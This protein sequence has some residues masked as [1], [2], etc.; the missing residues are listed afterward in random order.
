MH[1]WEDVKQQYS[2]QICILWNRI[3]GDRFPLRK[4]L[5]Q[6]N[7]I[8]D[9]HVDADASRLVTVGDEA[10]GLIIVKRDHYNRFQRSQ[11]WIHLLMVDPTYQHRGIGSKLLKQAEA[12]VVNMGASEIVIGQ[13]PYH[14]F[15]GVPADQNAIKKWLM[16]R[17]YT[18]VNSVSDYVNTSPQSERKLDT[19][20][21]L[22]SDEK[23]KLFSFLKAYF[24]SRWLYEAEEYFLKGGSGSAYVIIKD[25][26]E[27]I[28]FCKTNIG[29][30][31]LIG[32]NVNWS[33]RFTGIL[34]GIGPLGVHPEW[35]KMKLGREIVL[36]ATRHL[37]NQGVGSIYIDWTELHG[38]YR[39]LGYTSIETYDQFKKTIEI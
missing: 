18:N 1:L 31:P 36:L 7:S 35:R 34:G 39:S 11:A 23:G 37:L 9:I 2:D 17:G 21:I 13:D 30:K 38:F 6:Q 12:T 24:S 33:Q 25:Q 32:S 16:K 28:A 3:Y 8:E 27:I 29:E 19:E 10:V 14:Y 15:P 4:S 22:S 26:G 5:F 20:N